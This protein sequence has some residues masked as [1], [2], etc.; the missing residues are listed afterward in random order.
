MDDLFPAQ[1]FLVSDMFDVH[2]HD[3]ERLGTIPINKLS[4]LFAAT[5]RS[6]PAG[7]PVTVAARNMA[8]GPGWNGKSFV[9]EQI[10]RQ[11]DRPQPGLVLCLHNLCLHIRR[12]APWVIVRSLGTIPQVAFPLL[13]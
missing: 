3:L 12:S 8:D 2:L 5:L 7:E 9:L 1:S 10:H 13:A 4:L 11:T 6:R